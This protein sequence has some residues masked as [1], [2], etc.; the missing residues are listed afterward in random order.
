MKILYVRISTVE[1]NSERQSIDSENY[2]LLIEDKCSGAIPFFDRVGGK[3]IKD[4]VEKDN[5]L[6][7]TVHQ[8]DRLGRNLIDILNTIAYFNNKR[9]N[10]NFFKQG[11]QT[12]NEDG[13][14]NDISKMVISIL[15]VVAEM[16]RK[17]IRER[18]LE[19]IAIAKAKGVYKG[20]LKGSKEN[21]QQFLNK[22][23]NKKA[24]G[25]IEKGYKNVEVA[26]IVGIHYNTVT[27]IK[28][29]TKSVV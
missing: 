20:R 24:L 9:V 14:I 12:L 5:S 15:G 8:I 10:I 26:K 13:S 21:L 16:E 1:Q 3:R 11:L 6:S 4:L 22:P 23:K 29:F 28:R 18:Q 2:D 19:G 7:L 25:L 17:L 27:K